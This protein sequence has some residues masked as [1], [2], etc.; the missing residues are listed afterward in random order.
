MGSL[1]AGSLNRQL[2]VEDVTVSQTAIGVDVLTDPEVR[3]KLH[4]ALATL[5]EFE[6]ETVAA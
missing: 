3:S 2:V 6:L 1:R 5:V 4:Q